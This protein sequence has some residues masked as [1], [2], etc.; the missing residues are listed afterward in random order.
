MSQKTLNHN[1]YWHF[2]CHISELPNENSYL[3]I[4]FGKSEIFFLKEKDKY[5]AYE[6]VCLHRG[7]K[8]VNEEKGIW[9]KKC[10]YHGLIYEN[11]EPINTKELGLDK[12]KERV[13]QKKY[14]IQFVGKFLFFTDIKN[15]VPFEKLF[16]DETFNHLK[17]ISEIID[18][19]ISDDSYTYDCRWEVAIENALEPLH[20]A[21][22]HPETLNTL[23]LGTAE[24]NE[25]DQSIIWNH[26]IQNKKIFNGLSKIQKLFQHEFNDCYHSSYLFPFFFISSTFGYSFSI[27]TFFPGSEKFQTHFRSRVFAAKIKNQKN[28]K[29]LKSFFK[30]T[31]EINKKIFS[32]DAYICSNIIK[33]DPHFI[34]PIADTEE[35]LIWFRKKIKKF[36]SQDR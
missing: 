10:P 29:I 27:Q 17:N 11:G 14:K 15:N 6:N 12:S 36:D 35:K 1:H 16:G 13:S 2:A 25:Y 32:E 5:H 28:K 22:I 24:N 20:L 21:E 23:Q 30:S 8:L 3:K 7:S 33:T 26:N 31:I 34:G 9:N 18:E 4:K 19:P